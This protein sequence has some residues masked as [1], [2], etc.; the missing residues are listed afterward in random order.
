VGVNLAAFGP[1]GHE[2][3]P[4]GLVIESYLTRKP[5]VDRRIKS[6]LDPREAVYCASP[7][8]FVYDRRLAVNEDEYPLRSP[9]ASL[10]SFA[11]LRINHYETKSLEEWHAKIER[12]NANVVGS[13]DPR[14]PD[15][16]RAVGLYRPF[17]FDVDEA[18]YSVRDE[19]I[20]EWAPAVREA[21]AEG[22]SERS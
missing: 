9:L 19:T 7:S 11:R 2:R 6:I 14:N 21:L 8:H 20:L 22:V 4:P 1:S 17:E 15:S 18:D 13:P 12:I 16:R 10:P 3:R 5:A